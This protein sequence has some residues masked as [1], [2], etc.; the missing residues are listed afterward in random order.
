ML[1]N[2]A[3][4]AELITRAV[5]FLMTGAALRRITSVGKD[6]QDHPF[7]PSTY[8]QHISNISLN[9]GLQYR[10]R[11]VWLWCLH[12]WFGGGLG[13]PKGFFQPK[14][15][16][17]SVMS[18]P[19]NV[20]V[21]KCVF[22]LGSEKLITIEMFYLKEAALQMYFTV[23]SLKCCLSMKPSI[24][25]LYIAGITCHLLWPELETN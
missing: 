21:F 3:D 9:H 17:E 22:F 14:W 10:L 15:F 20:Y 8:H 25:F 24:T 23:V 6:L 19:R 1:E 13:D 16:C 18:S 12:K 11:D 5:G 7:K 2:K 4:K